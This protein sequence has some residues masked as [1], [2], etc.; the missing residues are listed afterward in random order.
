MKKRFRRTACLHGGATLKE[1]SSRPVVAPA[2]FAM[3]I[4]MTP[5]DHLLCEKAEKLSG[6]NERKCSLAYP[7]L[8]VKIMLECRYVMEETKNLS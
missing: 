8:F 1:V 4:E 7:T 2:Q 5:E 6:K 3:I